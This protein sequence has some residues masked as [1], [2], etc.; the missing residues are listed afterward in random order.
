MKAGGPVA[1]RLVLENRSSFHEVV[2]SS[3]AA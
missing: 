1:W 3:V 2:R